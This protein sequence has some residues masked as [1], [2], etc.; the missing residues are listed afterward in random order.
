M[1]KRLTGLVFIML[2]TAVLLCGCEDWDEE[3]AESGQ[4]EEIAESAENEEVTGT[5]TEDTEF[6]NVNTDIAIDSFNELGFS[7]GDSFDISF[8]DGYLMEDIP[9]YN[10]Y[11]ARVGHPQLVAYP[12]TEYIAVAISSGGRMWDEADCSEGDEITIRLNTPGKYLDEQNALDMVYSDD[13]E[14]YPDDVTFANFRA[15]SGGDILADTFYR[16]ASPV[17]NKHN[18]AAVTDRLLEE[19]NIGFILD[20]AD[21]PEKLNGYTEKAMLDIL[22]AKTGYRNFEQMEDEE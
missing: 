6:G 22:Y 4:D 15:M 7:Y 19:N 8:S 17:D 5:V 14:D 12:G 3:I 18:R 21:T 1:K 2:I 10:G 9:Y 13:R 20:L 16:G 11:Y